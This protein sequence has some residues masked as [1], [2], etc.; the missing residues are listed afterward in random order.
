MVTGQ[1]GDVMK[2]SVKIAYTYA[3]RF[4]LQR[5]PENKF[6]NS[7]QIHLHVPEGAISKDGPSA[8]IAMATSFVR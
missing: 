6:F 7:H 5:E 4:L 8:G 1:L 3:R 2:E